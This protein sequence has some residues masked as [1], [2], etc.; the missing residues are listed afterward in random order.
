MEKPYTPQT[1][2]A[3]AQQYWQDTQACTVTEDPAQ[4]KFYCLSMLPYPSGQLHMGH[5]RNY[6]IG[7][8]ISRYQRMCGKNVLQP[9]GWDAFGLPAENAAI[10]NKTAP[11][12]WTYQNIAEMRSQLQRLGYAIDWTRELATCQPDY[13]RWE[14]WLF[15]QLFKKGLVYRKNSVVNWDPVDQTVLANEQVIDGC[16]WRSGARVERREIPQWFLKITAYADALVQDLDTLPGWPEQVKTMQRNW[17]GRSEGTEVD[18]AVTGIQDPIRIY[19][20]RVDTLLGVTYLAIAPEHPLAQK[21]AETHPQIAAFLQECQHRKT[22]EAALSVLEKRGIAT[23]FTAIHPISQE[24]LPVWVANYVLMEYGAGAVMAVPAHDQRDFEFAQYYQLPIK[25]VLQAVGVNGE[26][27]DP[28]LGE[29]ITI[30]SAPFDGL[31][32]TQAK[33]AITDYLVDK[34]QGKRSVHYRL[35]DWG[36]SRQRYWGT[37]IPIIYCPACG[38]VAVPDK[39]LPVLL[40]EE[41]ITLD[42]PTSPLKSS[43][44][45]SQVPCPDCGKAATRETDTFDTFVESS[46]YYARYTCPDQRQA[47]LDARA[48]YWLSVDQYIGGIEHAVLHLL[49]ARFFYKVLRDMDLVPGDEPFKKLLTQGM[50][51]KDGSKMSKSKGNTVSPK[52][53]IQRYGADTVRLFIIFAAPPEQSLE[54]SDS[55]V[56]GA[57]RFLK[58]LWTQAHQ[59]E[60]LISQANATTALS[61]THKTHRREIHAL[62]KQ[63]TQDIAALQLNTVVSAAMKLLNLLG[64]IPAA[65][66]MAPV[67]AEGYSILLR[68]LAPI[69]PHISHF[70]W[71]MLHFGPDILKAPWPQ[72]DATALETDEITIVVQVNGKV[73]GHITVASDASDAHIQEAALTEPNIV[74]HLNDQ[75]PKKVLVVRKRVV[76]IVV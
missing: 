63:A 66:E 65:P 62:L 70:L 38:P 49:Y 27:Q 53:L 20:T 18:F 58:R 74:R 17:I 11:A 7:D 10:Q 31:S 14:Q 4:E 76:S 3:D 29:G 52:E 41:G 39:D 30:H 45:F 28:F 51:L 61:D 56:E 25:K 59:V 42:T 69:T 68:V 43:T 21:A 35:R 26:D 16:G 13:Y 60:A 73:R 36:I 48:H 2:E 24:A 8:V 33:Q 32:S 55:G 75:T 37:P 22:A 47:M 12:A 34:G 15:T 23:E 64:K 72:V 9:M 71:K 19:T 6:T 5:V 44:A 50:V 57:Y 40:P 1:I 54:W 67:I 46:W